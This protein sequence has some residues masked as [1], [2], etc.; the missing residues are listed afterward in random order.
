MF[1]FLNKLSHSHQ[2][3]TAEKSIVQEEP[4]R[5]MLNSSSASDNNFKMEEDAEL[6]LSILPKKSS[7]SQNK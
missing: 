4:E 2:Y 7:R 1:D 5:E 3:P 6:V